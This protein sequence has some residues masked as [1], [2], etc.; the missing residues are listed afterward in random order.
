MKFGPVD[1]Y[2]GGKEH[3]AMHLLYARFISRFLNVHLE[4]GIKGEPFT[5]LLA[6]GMVLGKSYYSET[7][8]YV[9]PEDIETNGI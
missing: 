9:R 1:L 2:V 3:S 6:Q 4:L 5:K 8:G 7:V